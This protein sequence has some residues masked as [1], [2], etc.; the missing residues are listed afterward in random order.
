VSC[1]AYGTN[2]SSLKVLSKADGKK[3]QINEDVKDD[4]EANEM[5]KKEVVASKTKRRT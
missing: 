5:E 2:R 1:Q 4:I 3:R